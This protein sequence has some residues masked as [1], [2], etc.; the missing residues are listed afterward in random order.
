MLETEPRTEALAIDDANTAEA[1]PLIVPKKSSRKPI[2]KGRFLNEEKRGFGGVDINLPDA[3]EES[4]NTQQQ[5]DFYEEQEVLS[6]M[7]MVR[8]PELRIEQRCIEP[9][10]AKSTRT[11]QELTD[12]LDLEPLDSN[13]RMLRGEAYEKKKCFVLALSDYRKVAEL[14]NEGRAWD[15]L[16]RLLLEQNLKTRAAEFEAKRQ[17]TRSER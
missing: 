1:L 2:K 13:L 17:K 7:T 10:Q 9:V 14:Q 8:D 16:I 6:S 11:I 15:A 5:R 12:A 3:N 4:T